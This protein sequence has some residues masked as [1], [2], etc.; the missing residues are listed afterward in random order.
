M[1]TS[2][3]GSMCSWPRTTS[4]VSKKT[5]PICLKIAL[6]IVAG[7][8]RQ[9]PGTKDM[10]DW[11]T[12]RRVCSPDLNDGF[13]KEWEGIEQVFRLERTARMVKTGVIRH[14]VIY[15]RE[16]PLLIQSAAVTHVTGGAQAL[17]DGKWPALE[18]RCHAGR[19]CL[20]NAH[21][22]GSKPP[23]S[24]QQRCVVSDGSCR[25]PQCRPADALF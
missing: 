9:K 19:R 10:D 5:S 16:P 6:L 12:E 1:S 14:E 22:A 2:C 23:G 15:G 18:A 24:T 11:N 7:G 17:E 4:R 3:M 25:C 20:P 21:R 8:S 13:G